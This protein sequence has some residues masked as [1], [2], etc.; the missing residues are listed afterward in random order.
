MTLTLTQCNDMILHTLDASELPGEIPYT[1]IVNRAGSWLYT[2][3]D[4]E[5]LNR[6]STVTATVGLNYVV[7]PVTQ[8]V[9]LWWSNNLARVARRTTMDHI[10]QIRSR[11]TSNS[12]PSYWALGW[13]DLS[14]VQTRVVEFDFAFTTAD[15][16]T[17]QYKKP[18][19]LPM[20]NGNIQVPLEWEGMYVQAIRA[21]ARGYQEE[22]V[23][24]LDVRLAAL[25]NSDEMRRL[26]ALDG[27]SQANRGAARGGIGSLSYH[28]PEL[29]D[30][31]NIPH[32]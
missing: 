31:I 24:S 27:M 12:Y 10:N 29:P 20:V 5:W 28:P 22:D 11:N 15:V 9:N 17:Y 1:D 6:T 21:Y 25:A 2:V 19:A 7:V 16:I 23:A 4:W 30:P 18:W 32:P 14:N 26:R 8:I 13:R 3:S